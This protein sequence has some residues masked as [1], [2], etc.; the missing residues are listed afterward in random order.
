MLH[1]MVRIMKSKAGPLALYKG[2][3]AS[4]VN[5]FIQRK[6]TRAERVC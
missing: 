6:W 3:T 5:T 2:F 4:M 1:T